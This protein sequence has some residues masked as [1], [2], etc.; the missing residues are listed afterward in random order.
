MSAPFQ[1][2]SRQASSPEAQ[3]KPTTATYAP[4]VPI[5]VYRELA[6]ELAETRKTV[7]AMTQQN[8]H[9]VR[10]NTL[11][12]NEIQRFVAAAE[13]LGQFVGGVPST[14]Q[15]S[16]EHPKVS[17]RDAVEPPPATPQSVN[18]SLENSLQA[19]LSL[20][21]EA[22]QGVSETVTLTPEG[23]IVPQRQLTKRER[24]AAP[25]KSAVAKTRL[26]T[27]QPEETRPLSQMAKPS[28]LSNLWLAITI[29]MVIVTAFGTGFLIM[30]P[31][32]NR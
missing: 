17:T 20:P 26:F 29:V 16:T 21:T 23:A 24:P 15:P 6:A 27:E 1:S 18:Q 31:L 7:D 5:S 12:R 11:L 13:Q 4:A 2:N 22:P 30:R 3:G 14:Q 32:L 28:D 10:Q 25:K 8:K 9:L 19:S